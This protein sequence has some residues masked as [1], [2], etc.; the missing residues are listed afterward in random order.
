MA[1]LAGLRRMVPTPLH[2]IRR[3]IAEQRS[4]RAR[5]VDSVCGACMLVRRAAMERVGLLDEDFFMYHEDVE[6]CKRYWSAGWSVWFDPEVE[7]VHLGGQS[8]TQATAPGEL[9]LWFAHVCHNDAVYF[10]KHHGAA[11]AWLVKSMHV[12]FMLWGWAKW[13]ALALLVRNATFERQSEWYRH[14]LG[15][16]WKARVR[17]SCRSRSAG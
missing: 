2:S 1:D 3:D 15:N 4:D 10:R 9:E 13:R 12:L 8:S 16:A 17:Q 14:R 11:S 7:V 5:P 6:W